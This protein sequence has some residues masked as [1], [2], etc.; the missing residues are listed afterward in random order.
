[1]KSSHFQLLLICLLSMLSLLQACTN[2]FSNRVENLVIDNDFN[3]MWWQD[4]YVIKVP[5]YVNFDKTLNQDADLAF[6][7]LQQEVY[8]MVISE[9]RDFMDSVMI[10]SELHEKGESLTESALY[11]HLASLQSTYQ[12]RDVVEPKPLSINGSNAH[13]AEA[14]STIDEVP[15][16]YHITV[17]EGKT[18][19]YTVWCWTLEEYRDRYRDTFQKVAGSFKL[20]K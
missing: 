1:M 18:E 7:N 12:V 17:V 10:A 13:T 16:A 8:I 5:N 2:P 14:V 9:S 15:I 20:L 11:V 19:V 6:S 3:E 4:E